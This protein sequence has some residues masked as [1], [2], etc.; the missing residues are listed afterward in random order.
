MTSTSADAAGAP[1]D[2]A[3]RAILGRAL[4][5]VL[6]LEAKVADE[7]DPESLH[8]LRVALRRA[9]SVLRELA[10]VLEGPDHEA[11]SGALRKLAHLTGPVRDLDVLAATLGRYRTCVPPR[12][13]KHLEPLRESIEGERARA[14]RALATEMTAARRRRLEATFERFAAAPRESESS[15]AKP[16]GRVVRKRTRRAAKRIRARG[17]EA[18]PK[19]ST[20]ALHELRKD[21]KRLRYVLELFESSFPDDERRGIVKDLKDLQD[22]LGELQDLAVHRA[23]LE[24]FT[25]EGLRDA[26]PETYVAVG[27]ILAHIDRRSAEAREELPAAFRH[28]ARK[29]SKARVRRATRRH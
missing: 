26:T 28:F 21:V 7:G 15:V 2:V 24:R 11:L 4:E 17:K 5:R 16:L 23:L 18:G 1:A 8:A 9:R 19:S 10:E 22:V 3:A 20:T 29:K 6:A 27:R 14:I 13:R 25:A 12:A